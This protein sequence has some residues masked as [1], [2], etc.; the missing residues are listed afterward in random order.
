ML[1]FNLNSFSFP[2]AYVPGVFAESGHIHPG[3]QLK[4]EKA[5]LLPLPYLSQGFCSPRQTALYLFQVFSVNM[6][7]GT[8]V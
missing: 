3:L 8:R 5:L 6:G 2:G 7:I 4:R 1:S